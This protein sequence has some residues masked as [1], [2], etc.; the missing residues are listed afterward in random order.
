MITPMMLIK[1]Y[2]VL[3]NIYY[4]VISHLSLIFTI[5]LINIMVKIEEG[6]DLSTLKAMNIFLASFITAFIFFP[7]DYI[8]NLCIKNSLV[9]IQNIIGY[10][11]IVPLMLLQGLYELLEKKSKSTTPP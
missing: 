11:Y 10:Y 9:R 3:N 8:N 2:S 5:V 1:N 6:N 7:I 4:L